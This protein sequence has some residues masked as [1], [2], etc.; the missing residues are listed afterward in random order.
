MT[1]GDVGLFG[2]GYRIA[3]AVGLLMFGFQAS[4]TVL[5]YHNYRKATTPPELARIFRYFLALALPVVMGLAMFSLDILR[6]FTTPT[7]YAAWQVIPL[8]APAILLSNMYIFAPGTAIAKRTKS[9]AAINIVTALCNIALNF[10]LIP[11]LG[12]SGATL[13]TLTSMT[14]CFSLYMILSQKLYFVPHEW[15]RIFVSAAAVLFL[16]LLGIALGPG[17]DLPSTA[18]VPIRLLLMTSGILLLARILVGSQEIKNLI[19][20]SLIKGPSA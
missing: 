5:V 14:L 19:K 15:G 11:L 4:L 13:A 8:L 17:S 16:T 10:A 9:I 3:S 1:L 20:G 6:I 12:I 7:Y 2:V 18:T